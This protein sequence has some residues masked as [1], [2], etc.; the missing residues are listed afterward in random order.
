MANTIRPIATRRTRA[1]RPGGGSGMAVSGADSGFIPVPLAFGS[2]GSPVTNLSEEGPYSIETR[3]ERLS[4]AQA[5]RTQDR[6]NWV[7][8]CGFAIVKTPQAAP[9]SEDAAWSEVA[10]FSSW[11]RSIRLGRVLE[12]YEP[13]D[14]FSFRRTLF[15]RG[16]GSPSCDGLRSMVQGARQKYE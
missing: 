5:P 6:V 7:D 2:P 3:S 15:A 16:R 11:S 1:P 10:R 14:C 4:R 9:R 8:P 13:D 12:T